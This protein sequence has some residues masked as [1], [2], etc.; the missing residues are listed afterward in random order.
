ML[1]DKDMAEDVF[2]ER[3]SLLGLMEEERPNYQ[4]YQISVTSRR[5]YEFAD[6]LLKVW[7]VLID[8]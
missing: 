6:S 1:V 7:G 8:T 4:S 5:I 2:S 3:V